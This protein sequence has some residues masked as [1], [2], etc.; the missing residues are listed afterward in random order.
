LLALLGLLM[1][2]AL[3]TLLTLSRPRIAARR[4]LR[5]PLDPHQNKPARS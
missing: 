1:L 2:L 3:L 5:L 4:S